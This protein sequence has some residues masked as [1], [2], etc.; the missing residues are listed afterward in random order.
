MKKIKILKIAVLLALAPMVI[1]AQ[2]KEMA[3]ANKL[4]NDYAYVDAIKEY[5]Q[6]AFRGF[7]SAE[8]YQKIAD[9]YYFNGELAQSA[10]WYGYLFGLSQDIDAEHYYRYS[11]ALKAKGEYDKA[12]VL[13]ER[14]V[15]KNGDDQRAKLYVGNKNYLTTIK[16][17]SG[18]YEVNNTTI[19][20]A[21]SDYGPAYWGDKIVFATSRDTTGLVRRIDGWTNHSFTEL[22]TADL[23]SDGSFGKPSRFSS[24]LE[25]KMH[26]STPVFTKDGQT[27]YFTRNNYND[28]R[29]QKDGTGQ[30]LLKVYRANLQGGR[31]INITELPFNSNSYSVA[32]PAL[33]ADGNT[34]YFA[35]DMPGSYGHADIYKVSVHADGSFG[36]PENL[37]T[38]INTQG[39][40]TFPFVDADGQLYFASDGHPGLGGL[41]IYI[42]RAEK[43]AFTI[44]YNVGEPVNSRYD[45]FSFIINTQSNTGFFSSNRAGGAGFDDIYAFKE[46]KEIEFECRQRLTGVVTDEKTGKVMQET[47]VSILD[48]AGTLKNTITAADGKFEFDVECGKS[49]TVKSEKQ[50]Y[51]TKEAKAAIPMEPGITELPMSLSKRESTIKV[52][53]DLA[54][55]F[56]IEQIYFDLAKYNIRPDAALE[57]DKIVRFMVEYPNAKIDVRTHTDCRASDKYNMTLS[58]NRAKSVIAYI[59]KSGIASSRLA[60]R[61]Y[62]ET[63]L[64]NKCAD[65]V[66]CSEAEHQQ[67][68]RSEFIVTDL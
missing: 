4:F 49:Y 42:A 63:R 3:S 43:G 60:G 64:V 30:V 8:L 24:R 58:D 25:T 32:H 52:G 5:E 15:Q 66:K 65:G 23:K 27:V 22:Y 12:N 54:K 53:T 20:S 19:N 10:K 13:L 51:V 17:N 9:A 45:D 50:E 59:V 47:A 2:E 16:N 11:Q 33:S 37:G 26:E 39:K 6:I 18:R 57:L 34:L 7:K 21:Y 46:I 68:R 38:G 31:W 61:G 67:N 28:G 40:E 1:T 48:E 56:K 55:E 36:K 35:S 29:V 44:A 14:F 62:G 41:D